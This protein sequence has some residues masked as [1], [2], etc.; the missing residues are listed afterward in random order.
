M[1]SGWWWEYISQFFHA[2]SQSLYLNWQP[3]SLTFTAWCSLRLSGNWLVY[4]SSDPSTSSC[5]SCRVTHLFHLYFLLEQHTVN[6]TEGWGTEKLEILFWESHMSPFS[7]IFPFHFLM[8]VT[9][10]PKCFFRNIFPVSSVGNQIWILYM[11][12]Q[13]YTVVHN[14]FS[15]NC[16]WKN[17]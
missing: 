1:F 17:E 4:L 12:G 10:T 16:S 6:N 5:F 8:N 11:L 2:G 3:E 14:Q 13:H 15:T 7:T 9:P